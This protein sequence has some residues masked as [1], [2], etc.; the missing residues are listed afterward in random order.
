[1]PPTRIG[2]RG[3]RLLV[4]MTAYA[5]SLDVDGTEC[6]QLGRF[7]LDGGACAATWSEKEGTERKC[8]QSGLS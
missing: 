4:I 8:S 7:S 5:G 6:W 2:F 3:N 1:M